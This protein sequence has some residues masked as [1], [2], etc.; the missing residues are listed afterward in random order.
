MLKYKFL[1]HPADLKMRV[2]GKNQKELFINASRGMMAFLYSNCSKAGPLLKKPAKINLKAADIKALTVDWL[3]ELLYLS[4]AK[5]ICFDRFNFK[6]IT[7]REIQAEVFGC[8]AKA[9]RDIKAVT[10]HGLE[11]KQ[12]KSGWQAVILFD[13]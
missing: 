10:Y 5:N 2:W 3:S 4:D 13:I 7:A 6:K 9:Q 1:S 8:P 12:T 11:I